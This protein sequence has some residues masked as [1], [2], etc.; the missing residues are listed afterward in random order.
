M[1]T[2][3]SGF[4][5]YGDKQQGHRAATQQ[6]IDVISS[7]A[8]IP[9]SV[10]R[11]QFK[12]QL[13]LMGLLPT[14]QEIID[15]ANDPLLLIDWNEAQD[16]ERSNPFVAQMAVALGKTEAEIDQFFIEAKQL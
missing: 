5:Y 2:D 11:R 7:A 8:K 15:G 9:F 16:F 13:H 6:E 14:V 4:F 3:G 1:W 12:R 10:T